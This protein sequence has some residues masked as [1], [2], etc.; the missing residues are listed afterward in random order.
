MFVKTFA[1]TSALLASALLS[2]CVDEPVAAPSATAPQEVVTADGT[3][4]VP[5]AVKYCQT[6][7]DTGSH[8][9][10]KTVCLTE[11][12]EKE[13]RDSIEASKRFRQTGQ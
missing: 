4:A 13:Q 3:T 11:E 7:A 10:Q 12:E 1:V 9:R 8:L 2:G 5:K 6:D